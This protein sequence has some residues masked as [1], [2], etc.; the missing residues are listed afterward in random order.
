MCTF[1][2]SSCFFLENLQLGLCKSFL[3]C[4]ISMRERMICEFKSL[5]KSNNK[6]PKQKINYSM[7]DENVKLRSMKFRLGSYLLSSIFWFFFPMYRMF[8]I[9]LFLSLIFIISFMWLNIFKSFCKSKIK[10]FFLYIFK[11]KEKFPVT[12]II[13]LTIILLRYS[14]F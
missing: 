4:Y 5:A 2:K 13:F 11:I 6:V 3:L 10:S 12:F 7:A 9:F 8:L 1:W 14:S